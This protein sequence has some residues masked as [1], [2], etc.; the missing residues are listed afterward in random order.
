MNI[1]VRDYKKPSKKKKKRPPSS[2]NQYRQSMKLVTVNGIPKVHLDIQA[3]QSPEVSKMRSSQRSSRAL[4]VVSLMEES[5]QGDASETVSYSDKSS[6]FKSIRQ[7]C[8]LPMRVPTVKVNQ[9]DSDTTSD[10]GEFDR[11]GEEK[12]ND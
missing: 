10:D 3:A 4:P 7:L 2:R 9:T 11:A 6:S 5:S 8:E 12:K 1:E